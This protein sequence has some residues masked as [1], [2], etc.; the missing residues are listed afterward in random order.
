MIRLKATA[1]MNMANKQPDKNE[2][3]K[4]ATNY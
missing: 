1:K 3:L 4:T 2:R